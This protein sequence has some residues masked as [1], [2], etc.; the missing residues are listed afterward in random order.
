MF[1]MSF[2][3]FLLQP[4]RMNY[5]DIIKVPPDFGEYFCKQLIHSLTKILILYG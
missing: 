5:N 1:R 3:P 4:F 2:N